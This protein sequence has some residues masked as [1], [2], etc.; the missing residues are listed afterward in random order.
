MNWDLFIRIAAKI[1]K[2]VA[3]GASLPVVGFWFLVFEQ[4]CDPSVIADDLMV[5]CSPCSHCALSAVQSLVS[6]AM[7]C[8]ALAARSSTVRCLRRVSMA[9][10]ATYGPP[11]SKL[12]DLRYAVACARSPRH[13]IPCSPIYPIPITFPWP[14]V[15]KQTKIHTDVTSAAHVE[16]SSIL[17]VKQQTWLT[18]CF[19][20]FRL[21]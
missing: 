17:C 13:T 10:W 16:S 20:M 12:C 15:F 7:H 6:I 5:S 11:S 21:H 1:S 18:R 3:G 14:T 8:A 2:K 9:G 19:S 4:L